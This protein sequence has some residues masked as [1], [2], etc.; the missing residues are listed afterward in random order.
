MF[1]TS[2]AL[3]IKAINNYRYIQNIYK[4]IYKVYSSDMLLIK[5]M[6]EFNSIVWKIF[7]SKEFW[8]TSFIFNTQFFMLNI[9]K[10]HRDNVLYEPLLYIEHP[11]YSLFL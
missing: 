8:N 3:S 1:K 10:H 2:H 11:Q 9:F 5:R 4:N 7:N 6:N